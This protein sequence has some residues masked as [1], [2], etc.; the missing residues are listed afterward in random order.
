MISL[1]T[2]IEQALS[3]FVEK[4]TGVRPFLKPSKKAHLATGSFLRSDAAG[5]AQA[6]N[7]HLDA[8]MLFQMPLLVSVTE[9]NGWLLFFFSP[10]VLDAYA[11]TL[12]EAG[13]PD[14]CYV[15]Q[16]FFMIANRDDVPVP[17]D[18]AVLQGFFAVLFGHPDGERLFLAAP[19]R[20]DGMERIALERRM[21]RLAKILLYER[22]NHA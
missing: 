15:A 13:G 19:K 22:R 7:A 4:Y 11:Q 10:D 9:E 1:K 17:D 6:L 5:A 14:D 12:P 8:C 21:T 20:K 3:A 18:G 2:A 16:R